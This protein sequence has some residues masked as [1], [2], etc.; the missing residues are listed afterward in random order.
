MTPISSET[1]AHVAHAT[2][3]GAPAEQGMKEAANFITLLTENFHG[4]PWA[5]FLHRWENVFFS[6]LAG[7]I[8]IL[9]AFFGLRKA[10]IMPSRFQN[11]LETVV[12]NIN[13]LVSDV[14]GE[15]SLKHLPFIGTLFLY[16]FCQNIM[17]IIP[18][19]KA[20]T[21]NLNTTVALAVTVF[22]YVQFYALKENGL[23][24]YIYH[25]MGSPKD[26]TGW[27]MLPLNFPLHLMQELIKPLSLSLRLFGNIFGEDALIAS[28]ITLGIVVA[29]LIHLPFG[30]PLQMPF[31]ALSLILGSIQAL[32]FALLTTIY[33]ALILPHKEHHHEH[34]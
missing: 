30:V 20:S 7:G 31:M 4:Q 13:S 18:G 2:G 10:A 25:L 22:C 9:A 16:I 23:G 6:W 15:H 8:L 26:L 21:S 32:V 27:L 34:H 29:S 14:L 5:D 11:F 33:I 19:L 24:D 12:E 1:T 3:H 17:G 28:F